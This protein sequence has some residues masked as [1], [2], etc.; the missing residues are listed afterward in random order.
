IHPCASP[1]FA[2]HSGS[3]QRLGRLGKSDGGR[4]RRSKPGA[5]A[6]RSF[7]SYAAGLGS[8]ATDSGAG[9]RFPPGSARRCGPRLRAGYFLRAPSCQLVPAR[10]PSDGSPEA[11]VTVGGARANFRKHLAE[12]DRSLKENRRKQRKQ[13]IKSAVLALFPLFSPVLFSCLRNCKMQMAKCKLQIGLISG[14]W[15]V[16]TLF[17]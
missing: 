15:S 4:N 8:L 7:G 10:N 11:V 9:R 14:S 12:W 6:T 17:L 1:N 3:R 13:R 16:T 2:Q 5:L